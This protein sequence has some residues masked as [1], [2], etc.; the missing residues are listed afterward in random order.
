MPE[1]VR[2]MEYEGT[3]HLS[4]VVSRH[5]DRD[6][7]FNLNLKRR[8]PMSEITRVLMARVGVDLAKS[9]IQVHGVRISDQRDRPFRQRDRRIR[10]RDRSFW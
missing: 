7:T 3:S 10:E 4:T 9:V 2:S 1:R 6:L 8:S 5:Q